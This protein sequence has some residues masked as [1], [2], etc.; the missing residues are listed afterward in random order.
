MAKKHKFHKTHVEWHKDGS[1]TLHHEHEDGPEHDV[2]AAAADH[3][4]AL[5]HILDHTGDMGEMNEHEI[6]A[7][8]AGPAGIPMPAPAAQA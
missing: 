6:P 8:H 1:A 3:D 4:S 5:D 7:E 2:K